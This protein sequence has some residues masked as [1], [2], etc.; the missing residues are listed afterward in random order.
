MNPLF[1]KCLSN[2]SVSVKLYNIHIY[3]FRNTCFLLNEDKNTNNDI[4]SV[5]ILK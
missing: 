2:D 5:A 1:L 4:F 3:R